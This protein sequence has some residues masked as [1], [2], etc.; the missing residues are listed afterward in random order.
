MIAPRQ[1]TIR[2]PGLAEPVSLAL[3][4]EMEALRDQTL[5]V[6]KNDGPY[7]ESPPA[8]V[9]AVAEAWQ[10][11]GRAEDRRLWCARRFAVRLAHAPLDL[12]TGETIVGRPFVRGLSEADVAEID[13]VNAECPDMPNCPGGDTGHF[14]P[15]YEKVLRLGV[16]GLLDTIAHSRDAAAD[17]DER[18]FYDAC[19]RAMRGFQCYLRRV[20]EACQARAAGAPAEAAHWNEMAAVCETLTVEPPATFGEACQLMYLVLIASWI[21]EEHVMTCYGRMDRTL[22]P[23]YEADLKAGRID[24]QQA[25]HLI[26]AMF[27]QL[28]RI[29]PIGLA[30][31]VMVG[32]RD[33]AGRDVTHTLTYL[34]L[35]ARQATW[36]RNP[37]LAIAWHE[38]AP[39]EL[40]TFAMEMLASGVNC[41]AFFN[42][43]V[44][45]AALRDH[46]VSAG[47]SHN[48]MNSTCVE[49]KP[50][51]SSNIW[52]AT[53]YVNCPKALLEAMRREADG[54]C[55]PAADLA[56]LERRL[57]DII[58]EHVANTAHE[59]DRL[60]Q[61]RADTWAMP[62]ASCLVDDCLDR[63]IDH[64][65]GGCRYNWAENSFVGLANLAD[66][67]VAIDELVYQRGEMTLAELYAICRSNFA[68]QEALRQRIVND[69]PSYGN[70]D[71]RVDAVAARWADFFCST[72]E[73]CEVAGH[74]YVPGFFC[75]QF[76]A[77]LGFDTPATPDGRL[78]ETALANGAGAFQGREFS[79]PTA[80]ALSTT[81][82]SHHRTL[83]GLVHNVRFSGPVFATLAKRQAARGV[84]ETYLR[85]GGFEIQVNVLSAETL[86]AAQARPDEY[87]DLLVRVAGYS[88]YFT[89]LLPSLQ[90]D[91]IARTE[92]AAQD[93][94]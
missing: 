40:M 55:S 69:L 35:A 22:A 86:R 19:E 49:I 65:R 84:I 41:P 18:I 10:A 15:N 76:H 50:A 72:T 87:R 21:G 53:E 90:E 37:S 27:I 14:H 64:D 67:L 24:P 70:D 66:G 13:R 38:G 43:E 29:C 9:A 58:G 88:N 5:R 30:D 85:R 39:D 26:A 23:F 62:F 73:A 54:D 34:C 46:G 11:H 4:P 51:G 42:D 6:H 17:R 3:P 74:R 57:R 82:W 78:A 92:F 68:G 2:I 7:W 45:T 28:N 12:D 52:V 31:A 71:P 89:S 91:V 83:G 60:W 75:S 25:L 61:K 36:L 20:A 47:D 56:E 48:Y 32:G 81:A 80:S 94:V 77:W 93:T 33:G 1:R 63:G 44:I 79:G 8:V 16:G 59:L